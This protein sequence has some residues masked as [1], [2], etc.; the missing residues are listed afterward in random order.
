MTSRPLKCE[1][2]VAENFDKPTMGEWGTVRWLVFEIKWIIVAYAYLGRLLLVLYAK[3]LDT[4]YYSC[5]FYIP[6]AFITKFLCASDLGFILNLK[7]CGFLKVHASAPHAHTINQERRTYEIKVGFKPMFAS[8]TISFPSSSTARRMS[9]TYNSEDIE[10]KRLDSAKWIPGQIL[11]PG[12]F[13]VILAL[14]ER[15]VCTFCHSQT[16]ELGVLQGQETY[17]D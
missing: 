6:R 1:Q 10:R 13:S 2:S 15:D 17:L 8:G 16:L 7:D 14:Q 4:C 11:E 5:E 3:D 12:G 9:N